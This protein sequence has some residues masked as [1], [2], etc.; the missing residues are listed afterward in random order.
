MKIWF[1]ID[2]EGPPLSIILIIGWIPE[3]AEG[4]PLPYRS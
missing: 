2:K 1:Q 4:G 3:N